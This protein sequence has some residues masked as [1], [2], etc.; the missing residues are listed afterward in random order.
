MVAFPTI[1]F[2]YYFAEKLEIL[3]EENLIFWLALLSMH[4]VAD[5]NN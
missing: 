3:A 5:N 4:H 2:N 1:F